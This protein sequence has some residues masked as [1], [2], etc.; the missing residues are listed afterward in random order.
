MR[1]GA[2]VEARIEHFDEERGCLRVPKPKG[3]ERRAFNLPLSGALMDLVRR[4]IEENRIT[5]PDS[6]WLFPSDSA[7]GHVAEVRADAL[8]G[9]VGHALQHVYATLALEAG[10]PIAELKF[11]LNHAVSSGGVTMGYLHPSLEH[12]RG[13]QEKATTRV[14]S[15]IGI[16]SGPGSISK[17]VLVALD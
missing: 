3:G 12:L 5:H 7:S 10:V 15:T 1:R 17:S 16:S 9:L 2:S 14:L 6:P 4:R 13:W 11:L 8:G